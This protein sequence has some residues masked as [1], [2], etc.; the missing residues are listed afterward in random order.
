MNYS[1]EVEVTV[2]YAGGPQRRTITT[3]TEE[4]KTNMTGENLREQV[5][6]SVERVTRSAMSIPGGPLEEMALR[7]NLNRHLLDNPPLR[8]GR[9]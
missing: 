4:A 1:I 5:L 6:Q 7:V 9:D 3:F 8:S 2:R